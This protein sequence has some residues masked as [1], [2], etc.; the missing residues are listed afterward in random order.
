MSIQE[1]SI[2]VGSLQWFYREATPV[3]PSTQPPV[4]LLHGLPSQ[5]YSWS[6]LMPDLAE[7]G[8]RAIAP[9]WIG[10][11]FSAK[12]DRRKF[13]YT[14][15]AFIKAL[16]EFIQHL[17]IELFYLVVQGFLGSVGLQYA[18]RYPDQ[19][20]RLAILNT[21][22]SSAS[23]LP[24]KIK[25]LGLPLV[26]DMLT[27]DPLLVDRTLEGGSGYRVSDKDL[28]V[29]R[30]PFLSSSDAGRSLLMTVK[31]LQFKSSMAEIEAGFRN[32]NQPTLILWGIKDPWLPLVQVQEFAKMIKNVELVEL[33]EAGHYPQDHWSEKV[34]NNLLLFLRRQAL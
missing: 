5:S 23:Q 31:N 25:Q 14:P 18:L 19:V 21:P 22:V 28:D 12:P 32:W 11:G 4:L 16:A 17:Q 27:Q 30:R 24:W 6:A 8:F 3:N 9:D 1:K 7:K 34:S 26:G 10:A 2:Q 33:E 15:D 29:Y 20:E 13:A